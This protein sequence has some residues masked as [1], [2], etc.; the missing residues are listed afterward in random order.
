MEHYVAG[1]QQYLKPFLCLY[2]P[3][4]NSYTRLVKGAWAPT[5]SSWG[6]ENRTTALRVIPGS[7]KSQRVEFRLGAADSNPYLTLA[8]IVGSGLLGIKNKLKL[9]KPLKGNAYEQ[10]A[11]LPA[12]WHLASNLKDAVR[13]FKG[14]QDANDIFGGK[15]LCSIL[16]PA[17]N[18]R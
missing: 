16:L 4:I 17:E 2:A 3:T 15:P 10:E 13:A 14:S 8:A 11:G 1:L 7:S 12:K 9:S 18:G 6:I 5:T